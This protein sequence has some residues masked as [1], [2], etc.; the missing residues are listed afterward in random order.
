M[1]RRKERGFA[2]E[3]PTSPPATRGRVS[4]RTTSSPP[5]TGGHDASTARAPIFRRARAHGSRSGTVWS[6]VPPCLSCEPAKQ[7]GSFKARPGWGWNLETAGS[8]GL[9]LEFGQV[10]HVH[11][12]NEDSFIHFY[13]ISFLFCF[14]SNSLCL[15]RTASADQSTAS[16]RTR[17]GIN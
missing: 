13:K 5:T 15:S 9:E 16:V 3:L 7:L 4:W 2:C 6:G 10:G 1:A 17:S 12:C 8:P 14:F 11:S